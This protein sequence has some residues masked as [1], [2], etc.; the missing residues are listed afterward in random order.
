MSQSLKKLAFAITGMTETIILNRKRTPAIWIQENE[1]E[2]WAKTRYYIN[3]STYI[4]YKATGK[5]IDSVANQTGHFPV[6]F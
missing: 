5:L 6:N 2:I 4:M 1:P 3:I